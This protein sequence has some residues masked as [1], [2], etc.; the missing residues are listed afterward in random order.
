MAPNLVTSR[1]GPDALLAQCGQESQSFYNY[2][3]KSEKMISLR[4]DKVS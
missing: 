3:L 4:N 2:V 1:A